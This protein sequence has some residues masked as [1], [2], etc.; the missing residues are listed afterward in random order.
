MCA[1]HL[2]GFFGGWV[3]AL[4]SRLMDVFLAFP[5][6]LFGIALVGACPD[7]AFGLTGDCRCASHC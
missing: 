3:D 6:L 1:G 4:I 5:L 2:A 7:H